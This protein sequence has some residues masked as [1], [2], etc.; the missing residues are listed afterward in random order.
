M[1]SDDAQALDDLG[2][3]LA[4]EGAVGELEVGYAEFRVAFLPALLEVVGV[5]NECADDALSGRQTEVSSRLKAIDSVVSKLRR[6]TLPLSQMQDIAGCRLT[7]S[8]LQDMAIARRWLVERLNVERENDY[9][10]R[11]QKGGYRALHLIVVASDQRF[12][13]IQIRTEVQHAWANL[14]ERL[15]YRIDRLIKAGGGPPNVRRRLEAV[16]QQGWMVDVALLQSRDLRQPVEQLR[17]SV[18][19][20]RADHANDELL[21][22]ASEDILSL[23]RVVDILYERLKDAFIARVSAMSPLEW[24]ES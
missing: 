14:S 5:L 3:R 24:G 7:V 22:E 8:T 12:A 17:D 9:T 23:L 1:N 2:R 11:S 20:E 6:R 4:A 19:S 10:V 18:L 13:E 16:S 21:I 15:A